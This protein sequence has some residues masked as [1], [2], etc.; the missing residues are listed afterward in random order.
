MMGADTNNKSFELGEEGAS[1]A[2]VSAIRM[3][4]RSFSLADLVVPAK[5]LHLN[6]IRPCSRRH[7]PA[8]LILCHKP[9]DV[10]YS[11]SRDMTLT[12]S[13]FRLACPK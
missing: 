1:V 13:L 8:S 10:P 11:Q 9:K 3:A 7:G 6:L 5:S 2:R 4:V 12:A